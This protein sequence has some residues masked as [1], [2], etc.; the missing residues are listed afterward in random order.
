[1]NAST[2]AL[3]AVAELAVI[4]PPTLDITFA[5]KA[6]E[7]A[8]RAGDYEIDS[9]DVLQLADADLAVLKGLRASCDKL[10][11]EQKEPYL[12]G[13]RAVDGF[14]N[15]ALTIIDDAINQLSPKIL[16]FHSDEAR[17]RAEAQRLADEAARKEREALA[18]R[19]EAEQKA[20]NQETADALSLAAVM[21]PT[22]HIP[23]KVER[24]VTSTDV[25]STWSAE[26]VD[27]MELAK[28]VVA[29]TVPV[30]AIEANEKYLNGRA[31]LEKAKLAI[32]GVKAVETHGLAKRRAA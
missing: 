6:A 13:G 9:V 23:T 8:D 7:I 14:Y 2:N 22:P 31:R 19:A 12:A 17:R 32:P 21:V 18:E 1:M 27:L 30:E 5:S 3:V 15:Q 11:K 25:R 10:R 16:K 28:A 29:G 26:V 24:A 4:A 20:G